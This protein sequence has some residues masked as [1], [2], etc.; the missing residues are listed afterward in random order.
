MT[1]AR[2]C[3]D[4]IMNEFFFRF[5]RPNHANI[6]GF[7]WNWTKYL[8]QFC[9]FFSWL[10][11]EKNKT[12]TFFWRMLIFLTANRTDDRWSFSKQWQAVYNLFRPQWIHKDSFR[13]TIFFFP[14]FIGV[15]PYMQTRSAPFL[16][17][18]YSFFIHHFSL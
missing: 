18:F 2:S 17:S 7:S 12:W 13:S 5:E 11:K 6:I 8:N 3:L 16:F 9:F 15:Y 1:H 14:F 10:S 4:M